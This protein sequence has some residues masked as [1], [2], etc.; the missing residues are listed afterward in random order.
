MVVTNIGFNLQPGDVFDL[1]DGVITDG[2]VTVQGPAGTTFDTSQLAVNGTIMV[3]GAP[4]PPQITSVIQDAGTNLVVSGTGGVS[5]GTYYV[6]ASTNLAAP[7]VTWIPVG[8]NLFE[9]DGSFSF[10]N[11]IDP[12]LSGQFFIIHQQ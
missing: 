5:F 6:L 11:L 4:V 8:T 12:L 9:S 2:G 10:T 1:F 3:T 7:V